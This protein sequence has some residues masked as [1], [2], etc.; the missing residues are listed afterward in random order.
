[1]PALGIEKG[2]DD[3][4]ESDHRPDGQIDA[5]G[6]DHEG[7]AD[8]SDDDEGVVGQE[9]PQNEG[10]EE[11]LVEDPAGNKQRRENGYRRHERQ[12]SLLHAFL[13][14]NSVNTALRKLFDCSSSTNS[15][16]T[17]LTSRLYSGGRPLIRIDVTSDWMISAPSSVM[18]R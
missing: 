13:R 4:D 9:M 7:D 10:R 5:A 14:L 6:Q 17:A 15:T 8:G 16:T 3:A 11:V 2:H 18:P 12:I 1:M